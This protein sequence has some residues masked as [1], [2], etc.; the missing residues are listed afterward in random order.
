MD[1]SWSSSSTTSFVSARSDESTTSSSLNSTNLALL[2]G[3]DLTTN[4]PRDDGVCSDNDAG[5]KI[6]GGPPSQKRFRSN[7]CHPLGPTGNDSDGA[8]TTS[9]GGDYDHNTTVLHDPTNTATYSSF[10][11]TNSSSSIANTNN[12]NHISATAAATTSTTTTS[13]FVP[14]LGLEDRFQKLL[15]LQEEEELGEDE[16]EELNIVTQS[17]VD[18]L[19]YNKD[20]YEMT[21]AQREQVLLDIHGCCGMTTTT[22]SIVSTI[23]TTETRTS[24]LLQLERLETLE[25]ITQK[26]YELSTCLSLR[27]NAP[28]PGGARNRSTNNST[29]HH[30]YHHRH[31]QQHHHQHHPAAYR[32]ASQQN[33]QYIQSAHFQL[34][35]LRC[36]LWDV[37]AAAQRIWSFLELKLKLFGPDKLCVDITLSDL[38]S[39][40][41]DRRMI[42]SGFYQ[43]LTMQRDVA[44]RAI[45]IAMPM[46]SY[47]GM[48]MESLVRTFD[49]F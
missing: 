28:V 27:A 29:H 16:E 15:T 9:G 11:T 39:S 14:P 13:L 31:Q 20:M 21:P 35:F 10:T 17:E 7:N 46:C 40:S 48:T 42:D 22:S 36:E 23:S 43:L 30:H 5:Y 19:L 4:F 8:G 3:N 38:S 34:P 49:F 45:L 37:P 41:D 25:F 44:G 47:P 1:F 2:L 12:N 26:R 18:S 24:P 6:G 32:Q 33:A